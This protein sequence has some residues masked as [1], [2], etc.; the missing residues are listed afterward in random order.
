[1]SDFP[2]VIPVAELQEAFGLDADEVEQLEPYI[3][4][5]QQLAKEVEEATNGKVQIWSDYQFHQSFPMDVPTLD[6]S[7]LGD[8]R[9]HQL[10][11]SLPTLAMLGW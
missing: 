5:V 2:K 6:L 9:A 11:T 3:A 7:V 8:V 10:P 1:M 4:G